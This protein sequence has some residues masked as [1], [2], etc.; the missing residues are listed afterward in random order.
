MDDGL[1]SNKYL[2]HSFKKQGGSRYCG[3]DKLNCCMMIENKLEFP[4]EKHS[5][6][7]LKWS[8]CLANNHIHNK[9]A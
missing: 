3:K 1:A 6:L 7:E 4:V 5:N 8:I 9:I 2:L